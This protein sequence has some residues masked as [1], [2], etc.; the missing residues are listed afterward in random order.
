MNRLEKHNITLYASISDITFEEPG[1]DTAELRNA[2]ADTFVRVAREAGFNGQFRRDHTPS[3]GREVNEIRYFWGDSSDT[4]SRRTFPGPYGLGGWTDS[5]L[6]GTVES[7]AD[8]EAD[9]ESTRAE[10]T[11]LITEAKA[12]FDRAVDAANAAQNA[13]M[14]K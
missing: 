7:L 1:Q 14:A 11:A 8:D 12:A 10:L 6:S 13:L 3:H 9:Y 4:L 5:D 2:W